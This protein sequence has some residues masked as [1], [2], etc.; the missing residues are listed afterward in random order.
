MKNTI[1]LSIL[2]VLFSSVEGVGKTGRDGDLVRESSV[3]MKK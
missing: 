3:V 2:K 1:I